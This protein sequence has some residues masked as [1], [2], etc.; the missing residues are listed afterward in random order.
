MRRSLPH[1]QLR[2][3]IEKEL[4]AIIRSLPHRQL[5]KFYFSPFLYNNKI[6][7]A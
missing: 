6:T 2:N 1:R 7:A 4:L 3:M 5:R